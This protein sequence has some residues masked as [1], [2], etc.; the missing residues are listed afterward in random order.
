MNTQNSWVKIFRWQ[1]RLQ[2]GRTLAELPRYRSIH[3]FFLLSTLKVVLD[4]FDTPF[5]GFQNF[6]V[7]HFDA[8]LLQEIYIN[9]TH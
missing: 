1:T 9:K 3:I 6:N 7:G 5:V 8:G 2:P 4:Y